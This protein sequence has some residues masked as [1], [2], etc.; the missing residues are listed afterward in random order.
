VSKILGDN[1]QP[2]GAA[3]QPSYVEVEREL[4][5]AHAALRWLG[6]IRGFAASGAFESASLVVAHAA[7]E[8]WLAREEVTHETIAEHLGW[9]DRHGIARVEQHLLRPRAVRPPLV[10]ERGEPIVEAAS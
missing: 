1:I 6:V 3:P 9:R 7:A 8:L 4:R 2:P 5:R 10:T